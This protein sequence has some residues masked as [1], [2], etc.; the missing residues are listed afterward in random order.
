MNCDLSI[1]VIRDL[2]P[3][4]LAARKHHLLAEIE[5]ALESG[6]RFRPARSRPAYVLVALLVALAAIAGPTLAFSAGVRELI[7]LSSPH[8]ILPKARLQ[9]S[10]PAPHRQVLRLFTAP[11]GDEGECVFIEV[12]R[13]TASRTPNDRGGG[14]CTA[15]GGKLHSPELRFQIGYSI[16]RRPNGPGIRTWIPAYAYGWV[17]P[18]LHATRVELEWRRGHQPLALAHGYFIGATGIL[19]NAPFADLPFYLA[20][21]D[22][23]GRE[24]ARHKLNNADL[25]LDW[26]RGHVQAKLRAYWR[27]HG[28]P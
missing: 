12:G 7:G 6:R 24:V 13:A 11:S 8:P 27:T 14:E 28:H 20:A 21:Y 23:K 17:S 19:N 26:K 15:S 2:P 25:Y 18:R 22:A 5:G 16:T 4:R 1:P 9:V 3:G 10:A